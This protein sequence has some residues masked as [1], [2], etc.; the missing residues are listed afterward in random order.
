ML[1][2]ST[3]FVPIM[4]TDVFLISQ[5]TEFLSKKRNVSYHSELADKQI[6][7]LWRT[8]YRTTDINVESSAVS[9]KHYRAFSGECR[10]HR[11]KVRRLP[12]PLNC[13]LFQNHY[14]ILHCGGVSCKDFLCFRHRRSVTKWLQ[15]TTFTRVSVVFFFPSSRGDFYE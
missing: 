12:A 7:I 4:G 9:T 1:F 13:M 11:Q 6:W 15:T 5:D 10:N 8:D 14:V 3:T 2:S